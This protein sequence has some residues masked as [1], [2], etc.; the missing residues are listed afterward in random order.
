MQGKKKEKAEGGSAVGWTANGK[1]V[2]VAMAF[3]SGDKNAADCAGRKGVSSP[4]VVGKTNVGRCTSGKFRGT[5]A[6]VSREG[7]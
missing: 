3:A 1:I 4:D 5:E 7:N 6:G 2:E